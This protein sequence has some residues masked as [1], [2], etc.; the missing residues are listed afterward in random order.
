[1]GIKTARPAIAKVELRAAQTRAT[2]EQGSRR[3]KEI[4]RDAP[5]SR[6][7]DTTR[8]IGG[9]DISQ[10]LPDKPRP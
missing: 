3:E 5:G 2:V 1:M 6:Q 8:C 10:L 4:Y 9:A 7:S